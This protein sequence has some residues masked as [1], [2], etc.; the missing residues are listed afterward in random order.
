MSIVRP[1]PTLKQ[2]R[3]KKYFKIF[4]SIQKYLQ[5]LV[6]LPRLE[7]KAAIFQ[8]LHLLHPQPTPQMINN[9]DGKINYI[10]RGRDTTGP[11]G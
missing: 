5:I 7:S 10:Y 3:N 4:K 11:C 6:D 2:S 1:C 9:G 8:P